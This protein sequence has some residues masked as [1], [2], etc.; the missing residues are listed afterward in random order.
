MLM[1]GFLGLDELFEGRRFDREVI[2]LRVRWYLGV[3]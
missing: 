3:R 2:I 1:A